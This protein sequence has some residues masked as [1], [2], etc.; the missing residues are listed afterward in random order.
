MS[1]AAARTGKAIKIRML[2]TKTFQVK[3]G[4]R[5]MVIP[6]A[7]IVKIVVMKLTAPRIEAIPDMVRPIIQRSEPTFGELTTL[8]SGA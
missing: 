5:N 3:S 4:M 7:R 8:E 6:G 1:I 2:V